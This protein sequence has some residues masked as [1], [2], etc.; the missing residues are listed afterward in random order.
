[1]TND[2][3]AY[4]VK[5][6]DFIFC[7]D[8]KD[9]ASADIVQKSSTV[10]NCI[11]ENRSV[12][13]EIME[14]DATSKKFKI[15]IE[16]EIFSIEIK[17]EL[18]QMLEKMGFNKIAGKQIQNI[19]APMPG[20]VLEIDVVDGQQVNAGDKI[21]ILEAMKMENSIAIPVDATIKKILVLEG[22][23]VDRGQILVELE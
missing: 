3:K 19:K 21:L 8:K 2:H 11:K 10:F 23:A 15:E 14:S 20:L 1:M 22:Q 16:G 6:N 9:L 17:D 13:A 5:C 18:D 7:F 4:K 12:N